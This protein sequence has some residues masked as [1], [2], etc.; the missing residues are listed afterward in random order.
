LCPEPAL[1]RSE[2]LPLGTFTIPGYLP[3]RHRS[4]RRGRAIDHH[5]FIV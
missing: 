1:G 3:E 5:R 2:D 4:V